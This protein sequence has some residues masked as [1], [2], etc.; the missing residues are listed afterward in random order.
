VTPLPEDGQRT[1][2]SDRV[3]AAARDVAFE[4]L[5]GSIVGRLADAAPEAVEGALCRALAE[6]AQA[7]GLAGAAILERDLENASVVLAIEACD[8]K[9][10]SLK[11]LLESLSDA[12][13]ANLFTELLRHS[14]LMLEPPLNQPFGAALCMRLELAGTPIGALLL[15]TGEGAQFPSRLLVR[16]RLIADTLSLALASKDRRHRAGELTDEQMREFERQNLL[17]V[18]ER[19]G[20]RLQGERGAARALGLSPSTLRDRMRSFGIRRPG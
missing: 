4:A 6:L 17:A 3:P 8:E 2:S 20:W 9:P 1:S 5:L 19:S 14:P 12:A 11:R 15:A 16:L 7:F 18:I 13:R 10:G